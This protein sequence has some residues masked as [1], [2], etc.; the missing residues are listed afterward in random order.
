MFSR[1]KIR[2][3]ESR[4]LASN[5]YWQ[6]GVPVKSKLDNGEKSHTGMTICEATDKGGDRT[7]PKW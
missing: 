6:S 5:W 3:E 2:I 7:E 1:T 4:S